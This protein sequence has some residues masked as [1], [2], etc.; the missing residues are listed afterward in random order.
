MGSYCVSDT[1]LVFEDASLNNTHPAGEARKANKSAF[2]FIYSGHRNLVSVGLAWGTNI[3]IFYNFPSDSL[4]QPE[5]RA[6]GVCKGALDD[7]L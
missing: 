2:A 4:V 3:D 7:I 1:V 5:T 6:T